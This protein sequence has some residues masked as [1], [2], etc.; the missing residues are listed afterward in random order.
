MRRPYAGIARLYLPAGAEILLRA[1]TSLQKAA[2]F[3]LPCIAWPKSGRAAQ[4]SRVAGASADRAAIE[5]GELRAAET[6]LSSD[7]LA[8]QTLDEGATAVPR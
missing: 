2:A 3:R 6:D 7:L 5:R 1:R 8:L 4:A